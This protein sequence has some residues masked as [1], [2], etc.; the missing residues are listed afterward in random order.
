M[1]TEAVETTIE[2]W[3]IAPEAGVYVKGEIDHPEHFRM[4]LGQTYHRVAQAKFA[5][6]AT[7]AYR[8]PVERSA[9][10]D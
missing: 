10:G 4:N 3:P 9:G 5:G 6:V 1:V 2:T 8:Q 7:A